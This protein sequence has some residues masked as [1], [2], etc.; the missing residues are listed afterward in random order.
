MINLTFAEETTF[1]S[2]HFVEQQHIY[3]DVDYCALS[4]KKYIKYTNVFNNVFKISHPMNIVT[5]LL[6]Y[7]IDIYVNTPLFNI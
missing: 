5:A 4:L 3:S 1:E 7:S 6:Y 2:Y